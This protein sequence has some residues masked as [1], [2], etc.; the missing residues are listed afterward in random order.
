MSE[1]ATLMRDTDRLGY[2]D[3]KTS[4]QKGS[5]VP[6]SRCQMRNSEIR[7]LLTLQQDS[8]VNGAQL[9]RKKPAFGIEFYASKQIIWTLQSPLNALSR[10]YRAIHPSYSPQRHGSD[11]PVVNHQLSEGKNS[12]PS[13]T[14]F[15]LANRL[16]YAIIP[17]NS[18][19][20]TIL[21]PWYW[22][23]SDLDLGC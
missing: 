23:W 20:K 4:L 17:I 11:F 15:C 16:S 21:R 22:I 6:K 10:P 8:L 9:R 14:E 12:E 3:R 2:Q 7:N 1:S 18:D 19:V 13:K 5:G